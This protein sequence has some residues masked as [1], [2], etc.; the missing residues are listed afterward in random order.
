REVIR[1]SE[2]ELKQSG[3]R[4][5]EALTPELPPVLADGV[6]I[7]Q[8]LLNLI[9]N[10]F[11]AMAQEAVG[12]L[13]QVSTRVEGDAVEVQV[14]DSGPG[15]PASVADRLFEPFFTTKPQGIGLGLSICKSIIK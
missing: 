4:L 7:Q 8:V 1:I 15:I 13:V 10:A 6:Q 11:D 3:F 5:V 2:F 14:A 12:D 9:R